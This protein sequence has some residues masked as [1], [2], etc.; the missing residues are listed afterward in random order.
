MVDTVIDVVVDM[1][2][3]W[4]SHTSDQRKRAELHIPEPAR[5]LMRIHVGMICS[6]PLWVSLSFMLRFMGKRC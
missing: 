2:T 1:V 5:G 6:F 4:R 3:G